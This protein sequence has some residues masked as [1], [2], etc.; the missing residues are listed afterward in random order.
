MILKLDNTPALLA[1]VRRVLDRG[2]IV[3]LPTDTVYGLVAD[4]TNPVAIER[5]RTLKGRGDKPFAFLLSRSTLSRFLVP[6]KERLLDYFLPGP[7]TV[8]LKA[9]SGVFP[10]GTP[11]RVGIRIPQHDFVLRLLNACERPLAA[12]SANRSGQ[13]PLTQVEDIQAAF[14]EVSLIVD[15]GRLGR[16]PST[17]IDLTTSPP[18]LVRRGRV[19]VLEI[20]KVLGRRLRFGPGMRFHVLF[21]CTGNTCRSPMAQAVL[22]TLVGSELAE[23]RSAGTAALAGAPAADAAQTAVRDFKA[24][25]SRHRATALDGDLVAWADLVLVMEYRHYEAVLNLSPNAVAKTFLL[26]EY[27]RRTKYTEVPD[28]IGRDAAAYRDVVR[29]MYPSLK[30]VAH[31]IRR[32]FAAGNKAGS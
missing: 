21:V 6:V 13:E 18:M 28:P 14:P 20:E 30:F 7:L 25:L 29:D 22:G 12:T 8:I 32:R 10:A 9:K 15:G 17:V 27:K 5:L 24:D 1:E 31:D 2:G 19:P 26:K 23:V 4:G 11:D 3:A 16:V